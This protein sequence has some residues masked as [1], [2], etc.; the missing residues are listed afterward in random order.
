MFWSYEH[1]VLSSSEFISMNFF[2]HC[3]LRVRNN[4]TFGL[5]DGIIIV[6]EKSLVG[7]V[8]GRLKNENTA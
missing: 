5:V 4:N 7:S 1:S 3:T 2:L 6:P 8:R